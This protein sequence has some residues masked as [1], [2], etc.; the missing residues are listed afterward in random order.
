MTNNA[1][2]AMFLALGLICNRDVSSSVYN[3]VDVGQTSCVNYKGRS[4]V[5]H[6]YRVLSLATR[7]AVCVVLST[8]RLRL[9]DVANGYTT[10]V[11]ESNK[12]AFNASLL[13]GVCATMRDR[14][15]RND[16]KPMYETLIINC[17]A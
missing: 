17:A 4:V 10:I 3:Q 9:H 1:A 8:I 12:D 2:A 15:A 13:I 5:D 11:R 16:D 14:C 6:P 7:P